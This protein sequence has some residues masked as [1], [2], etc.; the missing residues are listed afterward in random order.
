MP[1]GRPIRVDLKAAD[2]IHS[3]WAPTLTGKQDLIP[4]QNNVLWFTAKRVG[5]LPWAMRGILRLA[6]RTHGLF[7]YRPE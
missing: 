3:F 2:V 6:T 4:G 5:Q 1:V 7:G